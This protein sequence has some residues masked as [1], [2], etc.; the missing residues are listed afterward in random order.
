MASAKDL[1]AADRTRGL[2]EA[3][4][5]G[6]RRAAEAVN[7]H[8]FREGVASFVERRAPAFAPL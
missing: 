1:L 4:V 6:N 2:P 5:D 8:E 3:I 7:T